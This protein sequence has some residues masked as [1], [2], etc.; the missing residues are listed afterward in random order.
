[1]MVLMT[2]GSLKQ[3]MGQST[4]LPSFRIYKT[5]YQLADIAF[6]PGGKRK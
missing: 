2:G 5:L 1:M 6:P 4:R 3:K